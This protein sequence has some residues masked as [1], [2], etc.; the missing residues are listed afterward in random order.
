VNGVSFEVSEWEVFNLL[1]AI[2]I[3]SFLIGYAILKRRLV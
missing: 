2:G 1:F 3:Y